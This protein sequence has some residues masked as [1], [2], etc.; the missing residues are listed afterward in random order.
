MEQLIIFTIVLVA[1]AFIYLYY[2]V[3]K[4]ST[5]PKIQIRGSINITKILS[6]NY[7][8][9]LENPGEN[10]IAAIK[11]V[12]EITG[13]GLKEA[14]DL[15]DS[16]PNIILPNISGETATEIK[17]Q[18][19]SIGA[20]VVIESD[21]ALSTENTSNHAAHGGSRSGDYTVIL[22]N[23]GKNIIAA[24][25]IVRELTN[26]GLKEAKDIVDKTPSVLVKGVSHSEAEKVVSLLADVGASARIEH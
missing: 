12:R 23:P 8:V 20:Q 19:E 4:S 1:I 7:T 9:I 3:T 17:Y 11:I 2:L 24:I 5:V 25:K 6:G 13:L 18:F 16:C 10:K 14:K 21:D 22:E 26:L 15:V